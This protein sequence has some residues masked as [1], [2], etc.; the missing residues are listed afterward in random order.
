MVI[1]II[2]GFR[3]CVAGERSHRVGWFYVY[4]AEQQKYL[5]DHGLFASMMGDRSWCETYANAVKM[6]TKYKS[7][8][9][10]K[11]G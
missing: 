7:A 4:H 3:I 10:E 11:A 2:G 6:V 9:Q 8:N 5:S 1:R